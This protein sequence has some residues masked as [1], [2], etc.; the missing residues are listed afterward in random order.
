MAEC[1]STIQELQARI[2]VLEQENALTV[3]RA[4]DFLLL[5]QIS[6][7]V[8]RETDIKAIFDAAL[9]KIALLKGID[10]VAICCAEQDGWRVEYSYDSRFEHNS[11][12]LL[13]HQSALGSAAEDGTI[14]LSGADCQTLL[15]P[16]YQN[17]TEVLLIPYNVEIFAAGY[18]LLAVADADN[19]KLGQCRELFCRVTEVLLMNVSNRLLFQVY[20]EANAALGLKVSE[21]SAALEVG[22]E[23]FRKVIEQ[24]F[25]GFYLHDTQGRFMQVNQRACDA[26]G[27]SKDE[28]LQMQVSD[29][30]SEFSPEAVEGLLESFDSANYQK[31]RS[32]HRHRDGHLIPVEISVSRV[33]LGN[34]DYFLSQVRDLTGQVEIEELQ[35]KFDLLLE[36][37]PDVV[38]MASPDGQIQYLNR[39]AKEVFKLDGSSLK[40]TRLTDLMTA[41]SAELCETERIPAAIHDG[42]WI[43]ESQLQVAGGE[44]IPTLQTIVAPKNKQGKVANIFCI[45]RDLRELRRLEEQFV[46]AQKMEAM[47]TLVG[48]IAH[49]F[50]NLLAG[51]M[52]N[53]FLLLRQVEDEEQSGRLKTMQQMC[54]GAAGMIAQ[55]LVFARKDQVSIEPLRLNKFMDD[56]SKMYNVLIPENIRVELGDIDDEL[57]VLTDLPQFQQLM[58]NLLTNAR[59][60]LAGCENPTIGVTLEAFEADD[61]FLAQHPTLKQKQLVCLSV[62]DNGCGVPAELQSKV[63]DPFF[64]TKGVNQGTGLGLAMV[65]GAVKRQDGAI[66]ISSYPGQGTIIRLYLPRSLAGGSAVEPVAPPVLTYGH[67]ELLILADDD[68]FVRESHKD[69]LV[70]LGY[71]VIPVADGQQAVDTFRATPTV[72]LVISDIVMPNLDGVTAGRM[73]RDIDPDLPL[74]YMTGYADRSEAA[75]DLPAGAD[76]LK[77]PANIEQLSEAVALL[78]KH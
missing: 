73:M 26:L 7:T 35:K 17:I 44:I 15:G 61:A 22:E 51:I 72:A 40:D 23:R 48:G 54:Q 67:G 52:G 63:F 69:A 13:L 62:T 30:D 4:E 74:L 2:Q 16:E 12:G 43:G 25:D 55:L 42:V 66:K 56:F 59:D 8:S 37:V 21:Q 53:I 68:A 10:L 33:R 3:E 70:Q 19:E 27:Y 14:L 46:E 77:K 24:A 5:G 34:K 75:E 47:G 41:Q 71:R 78:L 57:T 31:F 50:N 65:Y 45:D 11:N 60:A 28:L 76:V 29:V 49:D 38:C 20:Q 1:S 36:N 64:T 58:I 32:T 6:E 18:L 39:A 9:E